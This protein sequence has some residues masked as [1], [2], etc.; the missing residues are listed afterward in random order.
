MPCETFN[1]EK[2]VEVSNISN[3]AARDRLLSVKGEPLFLADWLRP[4]FIHFEVPVNA[5]QSAVPFELDL[6]DGNAYVS[7]VAFT[8]R[9]MRPFRGG[10]LAAWLFK[11]IATNDYLNVRTYVRHRG[12]AGIYFLTEWMNNRFS[13]HLG[14]WTFGLPYRFGEFNYEHRHESKILRGAVSE[15]RRGPALA[16]EAKLDDTH[17]LPCPGGSLDEFLLERYTAFTAHE[18]KR[19][20]FRIWHQPWKQQ[21]LRVSILDGRLLETVWPWFKNATPACGNYSPGA[22]GVWMGRPHTVGQDD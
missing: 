1:N 3:Q 11:P 14:P 21:A 22:F 19:R 9:G 10:R 2:T 6:Y 13:I 17:F 5:L 15:N 7:L 18:T 16:Y 4:V 20:L 12:E 8:M